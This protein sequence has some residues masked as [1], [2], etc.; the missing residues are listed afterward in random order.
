V[1]LADQLYLLGRAG[2]HILQMLSILNAED[3]MPTPSVVDRRREIE[4]LNALREERM[5]LAEVNCRD[6]IRT[7]EQIISQ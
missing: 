1:S 4:E 6:A 7:I 3:R 5:S 2:G